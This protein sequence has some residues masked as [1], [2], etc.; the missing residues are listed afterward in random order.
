MTE[1]P[2][3]WPEPV[4]GAPL[5]TRGAA[6]LAF[7][8]AVREVSDVARSLI[9][10]GSVR[11]SYEGTLVAD[12]RRLHGLAARALALAV[13]A[14]RADGTTWAGVAAATGEEPERARAHWEPLV[15]RWDAAMEQAAVPRVDDDPD[16]VPAP[17]E[18]TIAEL[19]GWVVRHRE[20]T[21]PDTG[22]RPLSDALGRMD[23]HHELLH[24][25]ALRRRLATLHDGSS[26][27][28]QLLGLVE[29]E[30]LLEEHLA[31]AADPSDRADHEQAAAKARTVAAHLRTRTDP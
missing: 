13:A 8:V 19:D 20:P 4:D 25:A 16:D 22:D 17:V 10:A 11:D 6:E 7:A 12:A 18:A 30:A 27:P 24:L 9:P 28:A 21:D 26:P 31:A 5:T 14:E 3:V 2:D 23:P 15:Q 29:R 1:V